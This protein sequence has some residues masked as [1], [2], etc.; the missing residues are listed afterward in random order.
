MR[1]LLATAL[2]APLIAT[3]PN[4]HAWGAGGH[5]A[6]ATLAA[7]LIRGTPAEA[8]VKALLG[9]MTL[10]EAAIWPDCVKGI[11]AAQGYTYPNPGKYA[12]CASLETP[13]RIAEMASYVRR[14]DRQCE[15]KPG[16]ESCHQQYHYTD[17]AIQRSRYIEGFAGTSGHDIVGAMQAAIAVLQGR[18]S[19]PPI[20]FASKREA[21]IVLTH[22]VGDLHEPLHVGSIYLDGDGH[23]VDPDKVATG[24]SESTQGGNRLLLP[25]VPP[26]RPH[27]L[28]TTWD[29]IPDSLDAR[30]VDAAWLKQARRVHA[31]P[32]ALQDWPARWA[33]EVLEQAYDAHSGLGYSARMGESH[34]PHWNLTLP[35]GYNA[36]MATMKQ[37]QLTRAGARLAQLLNALWTQP[38]R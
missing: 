15:P 3:A 37:Q 28:H 18:P 21:L 4:A 11:S 8:Q 10:Q 32:G 38:A 36:R 34:S 20:S 6:V 12:S 27:S 2:F 33:S 22:L 19:T 13:E 7:G 35:A 23:A 29:N 26:A 31:T 17:V 5:Q 30:H 24:D 1:R 14:N 25:V 9:D 16:E